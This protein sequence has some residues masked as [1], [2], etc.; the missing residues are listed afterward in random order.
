MIKM[1][2]VEGIRAYGC[3]VLEENTKVDNWTLLAAKAIVIAPNLKSFMVVGI[4][5]STHG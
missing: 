4:W 2:K 5:L 3:Q 1:V